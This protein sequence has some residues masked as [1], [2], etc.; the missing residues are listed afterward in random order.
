[1]STTGKLFEKVTKTHIHDNEWA[2]NNTLTVRSGDLYS[3]Q[4]AVTK[5]GHVQF[6][7]KAFIFIRE[8]RRQFNIWG[9]KQWTTDAEE[10]TDL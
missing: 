2:C 3:T 6:S 5:G 9:V 7:H 1:L 8:F 4:P 10:V